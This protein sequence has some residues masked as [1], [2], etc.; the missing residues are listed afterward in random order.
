MQIA[1][2]LQEQ[3]RCLYKYRPCIYNIYGRSD[4]MFKVQKAEETAT[5]T[6]R[7]PLSLLERLSKTA[8]KE[9]V[10]MNSLIVQCC[11]YALDNLMTISKA[12][13]AFSVESKPNNK[14]TGK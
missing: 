10:S 2:Y 7:L 6:F 13:P 4:I 9:N 3:K 5:R 8:Q 11:S 14:K 12:K 1:Y